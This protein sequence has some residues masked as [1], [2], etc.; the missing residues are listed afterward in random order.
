MIRA[1]A[2]LAFAVTAALLC[3]APTLARAGLPAESPLP[4]LGLPSLDG[5]PVTL[6]ALA[7]RPVLVNVWATWCKPCVNELPIFVA[8]DRD[9]RADGLQI[10]AV[11]IDAELAPVEATA[12]RL[13]LP[14]TVLHDGKGMINKAFRLQQIPATF[15]Y[16]ARGALVWQTHEALDADDP[17]FR[18]AL[19]AALASTPPAAKPAEKPTAKPAEVNR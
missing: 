2:A 16:D 10:V 7:G 15:L 11:A 17:A 13:G 5:P 19:T 6:S 14:F 1:A 8:L 18:A 9:H 4:A 12:E 3:A